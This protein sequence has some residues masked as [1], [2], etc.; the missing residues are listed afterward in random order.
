MTSYLCQESACFNPRLRVGGDVVF[1]IT[2]G[3][4]RCFNPRLRVG[5]D[6]ARR[7]HYRQAR[8]F[9]STPP[10]G[11][12]R[13]SKSCQGPYRCFNPRLRVGG[14]AA[15][16]VTPGVSVGFNPRLRVGGDGSRAQRGQTTPV[17][18]HASA[19][20]ATNIHRLPIGD[21]NVSIHASAWE[22]TGRVGSTTDKPECFNPRL[23]VGG[24]LPGRGL[25]AASSEVSIHASAWE[26]TRSLYP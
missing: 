20:E 9:Q 17:S 8:V 6:R 1:H 2:R 19:W 11:R 12:R 5:G 4:L 24:D 26:A 3:T 7:L 13:C 25:P 15:C 14:D 23:R 22:A 21:Y 10:R 18:I 16:S